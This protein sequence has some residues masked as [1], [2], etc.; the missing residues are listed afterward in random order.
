MFEPVR[1]RRALEAAVA[2]IAEAIREGDLRVGQRLPA[3]RSLAV[4]MDISRPTL[5]GAIKTLADAGVVVVRSGARGGAFVVSDV[6]P[7]DLLTA[8]AEL[9]LSDVPGVLE[10]RRLFEL[11]VAQVAAR[12]AAP[13]HHA[14][15]R[16]TIELQRE[17]REDRLRFLQL[18]LRFHMGM[19]RATGNETIVALMRTLLRRLEMAKDVALRAPSDADWAIEIHE[20]T[21]AAVRSRN[22]SVVAAAMDEHLG[23]L[24]RLW[25]ESREQPSEPSAV[26][27]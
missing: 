5:R 11:E 15:M 27:G 9:R 10:A 25:R 24:E 3:E 23:Y 6:V 1:T 8:H 13:K 22:A 18:D 16:E 17:A 14:R 4:Q 7:I 20:R 19:A 12:N 21:L 2:Q 26:V